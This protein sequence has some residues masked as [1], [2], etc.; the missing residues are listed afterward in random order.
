MHSFYN[1]DSKKLSVGR[2]L[3]C[4][5]SKPCSQSR[6]KNW[7]AW[8]HFS[9]FKLVSNV[10][11][12]FSAIVPFGWSESLCYCLYIIYLLLSS[13]AL[14]SF[15]CK[16]SN[17]FFCVL[18]ALTADDI[19]ECSWNL[20]PIWFIFYIFYCVVTAGV[21]F[22]SFTR[23][24]KD[25]VHPSEDDFRTTNF[26]HTFVLCHTLHRAAGSEQWTVCTTLNLKL[27]TRFSTLN[28]VNNV[29]YAVLQSWILTK[30][31]AYTFV[32]D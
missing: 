10:S 12:I 21:S 3:L 26:V 18:F 8:D 31:A 32:R 2:S 7:V 4:D 28:N 11:Y 19:H 30:N 20:S 23:M 27:S 14:A 24:T 5:V 22:L 16:I 13:N 1:C 15:S 9:D 6:E 25:T 17:Y 29:N